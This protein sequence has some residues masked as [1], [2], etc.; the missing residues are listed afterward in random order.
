MW[1][2]GGGWPSWRLPLVPL[3]PPK[4]KAKDKDKNKDAEDKVRELKA[5]HA[6]RGRAG[7]LRP[8]REGPHERE[9]LSPCVWSACTPSTCHNAVAEDVDRIVWGSIGMLK[10]R[11][12]LAEPTREPHV[13]IARLSSLRFPVV[14][15]E[16]K[17]KCKSRP[18]RG[19]T[20]EE[21]L[22]QRRGE[23]VSESDKNRDQIRPRV[24]SKRCES[25]S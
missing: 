12:S 2:S 10:I 8:Q 15:A 21:R 16:C 18:S 24:S 5:T 19:L 6:M 4:A 23:I 1:T 7:R 17:C 13:S 25:K 11:S 14:I 20:S 9:G 3:W 22:R